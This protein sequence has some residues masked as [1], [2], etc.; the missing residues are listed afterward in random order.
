MTTSTQ[1]GV[2]EPH[3]KSDAKTAEDCFCVAA[4]DKQKRMSID[5]LEDRHIQNYEQARETLQDMGWTETGLDKLETQYVASQVQSW[6]L[7]Q[8]QEWEAGL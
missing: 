8:A 1:Y 3:T 4:W 6:K 5:F 2:S 7:P